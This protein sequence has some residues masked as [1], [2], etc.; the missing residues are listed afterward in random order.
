MYPQPISPCV[1]DPRPPEVGEMAG[2]FWLGNVE[3]VVYV[4]HADFA[5]VQQTQDA[6]PGWIGECPQHR[7]ERRESK[8]SRR[9]HIY[10]L[11]NIS[12]RA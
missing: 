6:E 2:G 4:A 9:S 5:A 1:N 3:R 11:T 7:V 12:E 8:V 10:A